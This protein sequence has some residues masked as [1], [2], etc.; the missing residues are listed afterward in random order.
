[1]STFFYVIEHTFLR[2]SVDIFA[3]LVA[4]IR[5]LPNQNRSPRVTCS[6]SALQRN[7]SFQY[8]VETPFERRA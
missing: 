3:L 2:L 1:M 4:E 8:H 7:N 6:N 5:F